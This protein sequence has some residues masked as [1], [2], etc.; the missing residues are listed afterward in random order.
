VDKP[1]ATCSRERLDESRRAENRYLEL[2]QTLGRCIRMTALNNQ[3]DS[4]VGSYAP[5]SVLEAT[6]FG[7]VDLQQL[8]VAVDVGEP[9]EGRSRSDETHHLAA[10][11]QQRPHEVRSNEPSGAGN[12]DSALSELRHAP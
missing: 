7:G 6:R 3:V 10:G 1:R 12:E 4:E 5:N 2:A 9:R 11:L 8:D